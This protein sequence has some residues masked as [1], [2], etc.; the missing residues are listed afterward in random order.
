MTE[1][2]QTLL[3]LFVLP[4]Y[5]SAQTSGLP[6]NYFIRN[7]F[8]GDYNAQSQNWSIDQDTLTGIMYFGNNEG[9]LQFTG[10]RWNVF[11]LPN[12]MIVRAVAC[13]HQGKVFVGGYEE[14]G[15]FQTLSNGELSYVSLSDTIEIQEN[16][17]IW[18][19]IHTGN[20]TLFQSFTTLYAFNGSSVTIH[21]APYLQLYLQKNKNQTAIY[22]ENLGLAEY[23][24]GTFQLLEGGDF[25]KNK[26]VISWFSLGDTEI[27]GTT[28][29]GLYRK[30]NGQW[31][32]WNC[33]ASNFVKKNQLNRSI[34]LGDTLAILGT[35]RDGAIIINQHGDILDFIN[36]AQGLQNNTILSLKV[37]LE[38]N[39]WMGLDNGIS[40]I[41]TSSPFRFIKDFSGQLGAVYDAEMFE[42][43]LYVG[44]NHGLF[45]F[46]LDTQRSDKTEIHF[47]EGTQGQVWDLKQ[48]DGQLFCGH[49]S[50]TFLITRPGGRAE[51]ISPIAGGWNLQDV[52]ENRMIQ[53]TYVGLVV[54]FKNKRGQWTFSNRI[55]GFYEPVRFVAAQSNDVIWASHNQKGIYK[56]LPDT[57]YQSVNKVSY[58]GKKQG[59]PEEYNINVFKI[60]NR[61]VFTTSAGLYAYDELNDRIIPFEKIN[62]QLLP[63]EFPFRIIPAQND[64]FWFISRNKAILYAINPEFNL[65]LIKQFSPPRA[66]KIDNYENISNLGDFHCF[67]ID[68]GLMIFSERTASLT[69][70]EPI[71]FNLLRA[72]VTGRQ[73][74]QEELLPVQPH[75]PV[76]LKSNQNNITFTFTNAAYNTLPHSYEV[77]LNGL[78][79]EWSLPFY[80]GQ[81]SFTNLSP[82]VYEFMVRLSTM[83]QSQQLLYQ[84]EIRPPWYL[85]RY[86]YAGYVFLVLLLVRVSFLIH[87]NHLKKQKKEMENKQQEELERQRL[88]TEQRIIALEKEKLESEINHKSKE[89]SSSALEL[90]NKNR[91]LDELK[92]EILH[93]KTLNKNQASPFNR[94]IKMIDNNLNQKDD[95]QLFETNFNHLNSSFYEQLHSEYPELTS[96]DLRFC[97][98][99]KM[100]LTTKEL[101]ALLNMSVRS[102]ELKRFRLRKKLNLKHEENLVDFLMKYS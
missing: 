4:F 63:S 10:T 58:Y 62:R 13:S 48:K 70:S 100:N 22:I 78:E 84:F 57:G 72:G 88:V 19:I 67:T 54:Y 55:S 14:F 20:Q 30:T 93:L 32:E 25:F 94:L 77:M 91:I 79:T 45:Y 52:H 97:A 38:N 8:K 95:W 47:V 85:T 46:P 61:V 69:T 27:A 101:A 83:P 29:S 16:E 98:F 99:L 64:N 86:A 33:Q 3:L 51:K 76:V 11:P 102:L 44:T 82:G 9:L 73:R 71:R 1:L 40:Y 50:G 81:K 15:Y 34:A 36:M 41:E 89:I 74:E 60:R 53:G 37:D 2:K 35:I 12:K 7:H 42:N 17:E 49:N 28:L 87:H 6:G 18:Q 96:K 65:T 66:L 75:E 5:L 23:N 68:N 92:N 90:A 21:K 80:S 26:P 43:L 31:H 59:F 39:I 24:A 56:I